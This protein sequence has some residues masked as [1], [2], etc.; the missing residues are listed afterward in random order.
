[1]VVAVHG[2]NGHLCV[3]VVVL[4][5]DCICAWWLWSIMNA[6]EDATGTINMKGCVLSKYCVAMMDYTGYTCS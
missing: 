1:M 5:Y 6:F 2:G 3:T 4:L